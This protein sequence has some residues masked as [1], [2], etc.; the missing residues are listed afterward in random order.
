MR[1]ALA[2]AAT[3]AFSAHPGMLWI[4]HLAK[5]FLGWI[6]AFW[7][8]I[9]C[10]AETSWPQER[11]ILNWQPEHAHASSLVELPN[12]DLLA[13]WFQ[14]SG[15]R[16]A[17]DVR[18]MGARLTAGAA[19][20][21]SPFLMTD[22]PG[23]PDCN[24]VLFLDARQRLWLTWIVVRA[25]RWETSVLKYRRT[26]DYLTPG[27]PQW[28]WQDIILLKPGTDFP[29]KVAQGFKATGFGESMWAEYA[30][31]YDQ[32]ISEAAKNPVKR[33][34]GW[35][36]RN[37]PIILSSGRLLL[38]LYSDGY[39]MGLAALS[40]DEGETWRASGPMVGVAGI[41]PSVAERSNGDLVAYLRETG[42]PPYRVQQSISHDQ[43]ETWS[44]MTETDIPNPSASLQVLRLTKSNGWAMIFNDSDQR[45]EKLSVAISLD[46]GITWPYKRVISQRSDGSYPSMIETRDGWLHISCSVKSDGKK[47]IAHYRVDPKWILSQKVD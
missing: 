12:G 47:G 10:S 35:M 29:E 31:P 4:M 2:S 26:K 22:T 13:C 39:N 7:V 38:P 46:E 43:G 3:L 5:K 11:L 25:N 19:I 30:R 32:L 45:R 41:Q 36:T 6:L 15:E 34:E 9:T 18:V 24:P 21:S 20:W 14:G 44:A 23:F 40:D 37:H 16:T 17:D 42:R 1:H 27:P 8:V 28:T 33:R